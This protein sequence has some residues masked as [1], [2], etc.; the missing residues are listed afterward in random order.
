MGIAGEFDSPRLIDAYEKM[1]AAAEKV[2]VDGRKVFAGAGG[3][4]WVW[5]LESNFPV[6]LTAISGRPDL[7]EKLAKKHSNLRFAMSGA[8]NGTL[9]SAMQKSAAVSQAITRRIAG[10]E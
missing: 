2:S 7:I 3:I 8:D 9:L 6:E 10:E 4:K 1:A 5:T